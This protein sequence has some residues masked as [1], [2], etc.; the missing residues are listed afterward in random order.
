MKVRKKKISSLI[1]RKRNSSKFE[2][3]VKKKSLAMDVAGV[4]AL[5]KK[6]FYIS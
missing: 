2:L 1:E 6:I 3:M 5:N 4:K